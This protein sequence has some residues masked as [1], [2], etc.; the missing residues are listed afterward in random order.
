[1]SLLSNHDKSALAS[2]EISRN[3]PFPL[4]RANEKSRGVVGYNPTPL[5]P[6]ETN[7]IYDSTIV[8]YD[9][10]P[11]HLSEVHERIDDIDLENVLS[12]ESKT[13]I[14]FNRFGKI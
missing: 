2:H 3:P 12:F 6:L 5:E 1:M 4:A 7:S 14:F 10:R 8:A 11:N 13:R 9:A